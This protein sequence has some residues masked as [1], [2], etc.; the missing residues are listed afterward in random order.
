MEFPNI[1]EDDES[2]IDENKTPNAALPDTTSLE[3][4]STNQF[5]STPD[6]INTTDFLLD[7]TKLC[8]F[9]ENEED[10][11]QSNLSAELLRIHHRLGHLSIHKIQAMAQNAYSHPDYGIAPSQHAQ[12]KY[13]YIYRKVIWKQ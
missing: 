10:T 6:K 1:I 12:H 11:I 2:N 3:N 8:H 13:I 4:G 9:I 5:M 7:T